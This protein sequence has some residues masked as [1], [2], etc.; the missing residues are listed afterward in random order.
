MRI[1][2]FVKSV[3]R[4]AQPATL[5]AALGLVV[6]L[7]QE[8]RGLRLQV[9]Q[10]KIQSRAPRRGVIVPAFRAATLS[11]DSVQVGRGIP[12]VLFFFTT[13]CQFCRQT[14]PAWDTIATRL[15]AGSVAAQVYG[16]GLGSD[17]AVRA[18]AREHALGFPVVT[19]PDTTLQMLYRVEGVPVTVV[20]SREGR[21]LLS[22]PTI[23]SAAAIDS[24]VHFASR[25]E[26]HT[27]E[28][29]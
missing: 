9:A 18:Y 26:E 12:Q 11:G 7:A 2:A 5:V 29:Q 14:L 17:S 25:S 16:V 10:T 15:R 27:S 23:L 4:L 13:T 28:L 1:P 24:V 20:L 21:V 19:L 6:V 3:S 22:R 8:N